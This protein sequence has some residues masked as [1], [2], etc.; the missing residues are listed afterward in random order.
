MSV[1]ARYLGCN[2]NTYTKYGV[3]VLMIHLFEILIPISFH[4]LC[5][6]SIAAVF[7][8]KLNHKFAEIAAK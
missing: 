6:D 1:P 5:H 4:N 2:L 7:I 3:R 8:A